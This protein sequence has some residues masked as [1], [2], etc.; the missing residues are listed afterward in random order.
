MNYSEP[1][2]IDRIVEAII[3]KDRDY[4]LFLKNKF[5]RFR[6]GLFKKILGIQSIKENIRKKHTKAF[7]KFEQRN[8]YI[9]TNGL[10]IDFEYTRGILY[11]IRWQYSSE[12]R[13][14]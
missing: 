5:Y 10:K 1:I 14:N 9:W 6:T 2:T 8:V 13:I 7:I 3:A 4:I 11:E 12:F